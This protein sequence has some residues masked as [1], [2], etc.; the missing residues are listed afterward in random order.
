MNRLEHEIVEEQKKTNFLR[1]FIEKVKGSLPWLSAGIAGA[2][3]M[4]AAGLFLVPLVSEFISGGLNEPI[5]VATAY[6]A[7]GVVGFL[8]G[9]S[10]LEIYKESRLNKINEENIKQAKIYFN[11]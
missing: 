5:E 4:E 1:P 8:F 6:G 10:L 11:S 3:C 2:V 7:L 9:V